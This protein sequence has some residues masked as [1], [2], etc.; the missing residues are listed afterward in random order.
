M[1]R[2]LSAACVEPGGVCVAMAQYG[3]ETRGFWGFVQTGPKLT[4]L[5]LFFDSF[6]PARPQNLQISY[7]DKINPRAARV[8]NWAGED[9]YVVKVGTSLTLASFPEVTDFA[10]YDGEK[11]IW[12]EKEF[13]MSKV[14]A[15]MLKCWE[16]QIDHS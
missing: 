10:A 16:W 15:A 7:N 9:S 2:A 13:H 6:G 14:E 8:Y 11:P 3:L 1:S 4:S 12:S 5:E